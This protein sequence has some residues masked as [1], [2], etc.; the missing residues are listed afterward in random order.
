MPLHQEQRGAPLS[1]LDF[2]HP[3]GL[4]AQGSVWYLIAATDGE[5]RTYRVSR[6]EGLELTPETFTRPADFDLA[7]YWEASKKAF[8]AALPRYPVT[9]RAE[10]VT[11]RPGSGAAA[12]LLE[13]SPHTRR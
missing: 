6:I 7:A 4:V 10:A 1:P 2:D 12:P 13:S 8:R 5:T 9:V 11:F 3:L